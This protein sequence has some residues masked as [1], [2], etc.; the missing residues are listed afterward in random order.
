MAHT[1]SLPHEKVK[2]VVLEEEEE[3]DE[4]AAEDEA[5]DEE[6][7]P[8]F[9]LLFAADEGEDE[10]DAEE[11]FVVAV[12]VTLSVRASW[13]RPVVWS[14]RPKW[15][16]VFWRNSRKAGHR[17]LLHPDPIFLIVRPVEIVSLAGIPLRSNFRAFTPLA[18]SRRNAATALE[19]GPFDLDDEALFSHGCC[20]SRNSE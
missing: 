17:L 9:P 14:S 12:V 1:T 6:A 10:E 20:R 19:F 11:E 8:L 16:T 7:A 2:R 18:R 13:R 3:E 5:D 15:S 4:E